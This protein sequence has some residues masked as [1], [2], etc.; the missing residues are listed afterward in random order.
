MYIGTITCSYFMRIYDYRQPAN[1]NWEAMSRKWRGELTNGGFL[2]LAHEIRAIGYDALEIWE[3]MFSFYAHTGDDA[4]TLAKE[5]RSMGYQKLVYCI[6]GWSAASVAVV[7]RAY[8]FANALGAEI[9]TGCIVRR[10]APALLPALEAAGKTYGI[11]FAIE[12][13]P[14]PNLGSPEEVSGVA[15]LYET[16]GA[17]LETG[18]LFSAGYD[19]PASMDVLR[20]KIFHT[21]LKDAV[22]D[23][24]A[25]LALGDGDIPLRDVLNRLKEAKFTGM[26]S[27][28]IETPYD[29]TPNLAKS[30]AYVRS[31]L[32]E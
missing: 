4:A 32:H 22:K 3:P 7:D 1:F 26:L 13:H 23:S 10:D 15:R 6:G 19:L 18:Y 27:V 29:P 31:L 17:N 21:H 20:G 16:V 2:G 28:E 24:Y 25:C 8:R 12:N 30:L 11:R 5:L 9:M 14:D